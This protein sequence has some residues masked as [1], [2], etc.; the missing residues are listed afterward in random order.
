MDSEQLNL[1]LTNLVDLLADVEDFQDKILIAKTLFYNVL[2][3]GKLGCFINESQ[4]QDYNLLIIETLDEIVDYINNTIVMDENDF[5]RKLTKLKRVNP[6]FADIIDES[7]SNY[8][9]T[10]KNIQKNY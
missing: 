5:I 6:S 8:I 10:K 7:F 1:K 4:N 3:Q 2:L 9:K